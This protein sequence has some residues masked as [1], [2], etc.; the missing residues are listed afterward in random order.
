[1]ANIK[2]RIIKSFKGDSSDKKELSKKEADAKVKRVMKAAGN[3]KAKKLRP[4][5]YEMIGGSDLY[6]SPED[7]EKILKEFIKEFNLKKPTKR[8]MG[9]IVKKGYGK[10]QRGY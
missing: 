8:R 4:D 2:K 7:T 3:P 5:Q 6:Y 9:G 10:A 1:M